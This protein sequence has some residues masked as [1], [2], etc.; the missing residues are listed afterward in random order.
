MLCFTGYFSLKFAEIAFVSLS[1]DSMSSSHVI[2][3]LSIVLA[4]YILFSQLHVA[5]LQI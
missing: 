2:A 1:Y 3:E 4:K 5:G